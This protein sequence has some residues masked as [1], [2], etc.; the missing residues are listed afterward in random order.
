MEELFFV[1]G[2]GAPRHNTRCNGTK[3]YKYKYKINFPLYLVN[4][5]APLTS[6]VEELEKICTVTTIRPSPARPTMD[7]H[8]MPDSQNRPSNLPC[9]RTHVHFA[10]PISTTSHT[11]MVSEP[12][13]KH[14]PIAPSPPP[15]TPTPTPPY[16]GLCPALLEARQM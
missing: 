10:T 11:T 4:Y 14:A 2:T 7:N 8:R 12:S 13:N 3:Q 6:Q 5:V 16:K 15:P 1:V 9:R